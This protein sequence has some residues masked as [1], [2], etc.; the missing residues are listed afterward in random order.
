MDDTT[1]TQIMQA[2]DTRFGDAVEFLSELTTHPSTRGNKQSAQTFMADA[3]QSRGYEVDCW[4]ID[5]DDIAHM[6]GF[7]PAIGAYDDAAKR[8]VEEVLQQAAQQN[9]FLR[10]NQPEIIYHGFQA[11]G[12]ALS[13]DT[14]KSA[15][16]AISALESAHTAVT[17]TDLNKLAITATTD[18]R[19]FGLYANTP[20]LVYGPKAEAIHGFNERVDLESTRRVTQTTA[21]FIARWCGLETL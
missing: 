4:Q 10:N 14:S 18:A 6:P 11:E 8:E 5:V 20:A 7:S 3:L 13:D 12:Y 1:K 9:D 15:G 17:G 19:L 2:V 21:L 16:S